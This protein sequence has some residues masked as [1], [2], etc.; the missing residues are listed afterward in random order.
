VQEN[1]NISKRD[2]KG[3]AVAAALVKYILSYVVIQYIIDNVSMLYDYILSVLPFLNYYYYYY[4]EIIYLTTH[5]N[6]YN[7]QL[8]Y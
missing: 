3:S 5:F 8:V 6:G 1:N 4:N 7:H 2:R